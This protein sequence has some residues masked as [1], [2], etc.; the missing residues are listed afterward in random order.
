MT[1]NCSNVLE[2]L[3]LRGIEETFGTWVRLENIKR[4]ALNVF[5]LQWKTTHFSICTSGRGKNEDNMV[6]YLYFL[7]L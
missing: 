1:D 7:E 5:S 2:V 4:A 3:D 6:F